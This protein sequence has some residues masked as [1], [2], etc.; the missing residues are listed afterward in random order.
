MPGHG[1]E[2]LAFALPPLVLIGLLVGA[3]LYARRHADG[4]SDGEARS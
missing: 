2:L 3:A 1:P 4:S